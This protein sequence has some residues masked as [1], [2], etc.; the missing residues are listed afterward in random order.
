MD[1]VAELL[2]TRYRRFCGV[3][4]LGEGIIVTVTLIM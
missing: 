2:K 3:L 1:E 4:D